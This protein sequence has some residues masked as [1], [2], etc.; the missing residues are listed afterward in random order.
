MIKDTGL[1]YYD[2]DYNKAPYDPTHINENAITSIYDI[3]LENGTRSI[4]NRKTG[5]KT[6]KQYPREIR[7]SPEMKNLIQVV[8]G[9]QKDVKRINSCI[10]KND[11]EAWLKKNK[12]H[13]WQAHEA[14][15]IGPNGVPDGINEVF[16]T[17]ANGNIRVI[18]GYGLSKSKYPERKIY[19]SAF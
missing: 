19:Y 2:V 12:K 1:Q 13:Q 7:T 10:T 16:V 3:P 4:L 5:E 9:L 6:I 8:A 11:A 17:D 14:D 18:N 15:I